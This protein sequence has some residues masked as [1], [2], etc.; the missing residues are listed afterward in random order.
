MLGYLLKAVTVATLLAL[1]AISTEAKRSAPDEKGKKELSLGEKL[2]L[3]ENDE[4]RDS[5]R[6]LISPLLD[7]SFEEANSIL[8][9]AELLKP[10]GFKRRERRQ[11]ATKEGKE[12]G[13]KQKGAKEKAAK[14]KPAKGKAAKAKPAQGK[15][16]KEKAAKG[17]AA[18]GKGTNGGAA[19][20]LG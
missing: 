16:A 14:A 18:K 20:P 10:F 9:I 13:V 7:N 6:G 5:L 4:L 19:A 15:A 17:K 8:R 1:L 11:K 12:K 3:I 2:K